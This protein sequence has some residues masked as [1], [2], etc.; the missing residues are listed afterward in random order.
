[1]AQ[2][3]KKL[4]AVQET[5]VRFLGWEDPLQKEWLPT[6]VFLPGEFHGEEPDGLYKSMG[7]QRDERLTLSLFTSAMSATAA[8]KTPNIIFTE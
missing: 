2:L 1:M 3:V 7:L 8:N 6:L 5:W 4:R